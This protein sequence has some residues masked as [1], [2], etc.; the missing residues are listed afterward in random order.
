M[1]L[2]DILSQ[3]EELRS[4]WDVRDLIQ[5]ADEFLVAAWEEKSAP[6][7]HDVSRIGR[8]QQLECVTI[9]YLLCCDNYFAAASLGIRMFVED[10]YLLDDAFKMAAV[11]LN[12]FAKNV[13]SNIWDESTK[14]TLKSDL[15]K[16]LR[17][18]RRIEVDVGKCVIYAIELDNRW[19]NHPILEM[20]NTNTIGLFDDCCFDN[21]YIGIVAQ[22]GNHN[23]T[24]NLSLKSK[25]EGLQRINLDKAT[26]FTCS[27]FTATAPVAI[28]MIIDNS[29]SMEVDSFIIV[30]LDGSTFDGRTMCSLK[31]QIQQLNNNRE[32]QVH[33][34]ILGIQIDDERI[35]NDCRYICSASKL[36][37]YYD[38]NVLNI[39][40]V[41]GMIR[42]S[43]RGPLICDTLSKGLTMEKF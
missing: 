30:I 16:M 43:I 36:S 20:I 32:T 35:I 33:I 4:V 27:E 2:S 6:L 10:T 23:V 15:R 25:N 17:Q 38:I 1:L 3:D 22:A 18:R 40:S 24:T 21:D 9:R 14:A 41:F 7:F 26:S 11:A 39:D 29:I 8:L 12:K 19:T 42:T 31:I 13:S 28:Q 5:D 34:L 37:R